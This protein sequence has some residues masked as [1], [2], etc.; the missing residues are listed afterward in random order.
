MST[1]TGPFQGVNLLSVLRLLLIV[2]VV[3]VTGILLILCIG[4]RFLESMSI[5]NPQTKALLEEFRRYLRMNALRII[6]GW[7][8]YLITRRKLTTPPRP[9]P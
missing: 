8:I 6:V 1:P 3:G 5:D 9:Q 2:Y 7:P 4:Y